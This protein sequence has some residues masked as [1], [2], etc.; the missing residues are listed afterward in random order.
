MKGKYKGLIIPNIHNATIDI[1]NWTYDCGCLGNAD[2]N[3][4]KAMCDHI[5]GCSGC[6]FSYSNR[7]TTIEYLV[8]YTYITK[9]QALQFT[10]DN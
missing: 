7:N 9:E 5:R 10:L 1:H 2:I 4:I 6:L 8:E 3:N